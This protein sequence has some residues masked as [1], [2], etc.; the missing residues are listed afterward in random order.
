VQRLARALR[1]EWGVARVAP[2][3]CTGE[4]AF[5]ALLRLYGP[6]YL[7]AGLGKVLPLP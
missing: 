3:H 4:P 1:E 2:G 6:A 5:A 7:Y